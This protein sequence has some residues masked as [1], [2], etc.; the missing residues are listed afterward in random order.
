MTIPPP[1][2]NI[3]W[4]TL[5][6]VAIGVVWIWSVTGWKLLSHTSYGKIIRG[7]NVAISI[8]MAVLAAVVA[9]SLPIFSEP[10]ISSTIAGLISGAAI[11]LHSAL[12]PIKEGFWHHRRLRYI[13]S[14]TIIVVTTA[15]GNAFPTPI[16]IPIASAAVMFHRHHLIRM[17]MLSQCLEDI[18]SLQH[19]ILTYQADIQQENTLQNSSNDKIANAS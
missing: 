19:K 14:G 18:Q 10:F 8:S 16:I 11:C 12:D 1:I 9:F 3:T 2:V 6:I 7:R 15:L 5:A 17:Q 4:S 13:V